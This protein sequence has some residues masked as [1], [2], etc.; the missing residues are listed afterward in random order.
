MKQNYIKIVLIY[1]ILVIALYFYYTFPREINETY[2]GIQYKLGDSKYEESIIIKVNG[3][4]YKKLILKSY[5]QGSMTIDEKEISKLKLRFDNNAEWM[6]G[7]NDEIGEFE[8]FG[9]IY[10]KGRFDEFTICVFEK[11]EKPGQKGWN[12]NDGFMISFPAKNRAEALEISQKL[13]ENDLI[14]PLQ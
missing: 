5:F 10:I 2:H 14:I 9:S 13:M 11:G 8:S 4:V 7:F 1:I 3:W 6:I 12:S